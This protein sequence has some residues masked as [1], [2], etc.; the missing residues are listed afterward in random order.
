MPTIIPQM[1]PHLL[2]PF[3]YQQITNL[4]LDFI[5]FETV[6]FICLA[7]LQIAVELW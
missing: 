4:Y 2:S 6:L 5:E 3:D 1:G 7:K